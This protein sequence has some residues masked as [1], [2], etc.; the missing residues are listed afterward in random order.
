MLDELHKIELQSFE[1]EAFSKEQIGYLLTDYN[2][3][4]L[5]AKLNDQIAGFIIGRIDLVRNCITGHIM[6]V[7]V[8]TEF[9]RHGIG[10]RLMIEIE[11]V[12]R[13]KGVK[14]IRLE[15]R[16]GNKAAIGLYE[17][18]GFKRISK[19]KN[20]YGKAHGFYFKKALNGGE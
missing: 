17:K 1:E 18:L 8:G 10:Q 11:E 2:S 14:E 5:V 15:V 6:T 7:D 9:R 20:Y 19:L 4:G 3:I 12:F 13:Q 16:E